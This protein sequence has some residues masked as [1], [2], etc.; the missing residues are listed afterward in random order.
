MGRDDKKAQGQL[1]RFCLLM[2][3]PFF[4]N[5]LLSKDKRQWS[6]FCERNCLSERDLD[7]WDYDIARQDHLVSVHSQMSQTF[8]AEGR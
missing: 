7:L 3:I 2:N 6:L 8:E 1:V 4:K 5:E